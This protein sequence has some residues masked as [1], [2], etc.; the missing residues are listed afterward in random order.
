MAALLDELRHPAPFAGSALDGLDLE[1]RRTVR[2][3]RATGTTSTTTGTT[4]GTTTD[5]QEETA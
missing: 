3:R 5:S 4:P 1:V 2:E